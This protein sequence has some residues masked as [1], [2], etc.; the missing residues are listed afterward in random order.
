ML[1]DLRLAWKRLR[2]APGFALAAVVT[3]ALAVGANTA[4]FAV[5]DAVV[6]RPLPYADPDQLFLVR[7]LDPATGMQSW[8]V[9]FA[10]VDALQQRHSGI[11]GVALRS[12]TIMTV[13]AGP[14]GA[15]FVETLHASTDYFRV[16]GVRAARGRLFEPDDAGSRAAV[17]TYESWQSRF[18]GDEAIVGRD[19]VLA[20]NAHTIVGILPPKF[21]FPSESLMFGAG[22]TGRAE[23]VTV[24]RPRRPN[25]PLPAMNT[26]VRLKPGVTREQAQAE[27][28]VIAQ[29]T[30]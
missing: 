12:T 30:L 10:I 25:S 28:D 6:F 14:D 22:T 20:G 27:L 2:S 17:L 13:H 7:S 26:V 8:A 1:D 21:I 24:S 15:E 16:L 18:G 29:S 23:W 4:I 9:P 3:L 19:V 11:A 5:A